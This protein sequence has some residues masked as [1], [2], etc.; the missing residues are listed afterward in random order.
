MI[1]LIQRVKQARVQ[2]AGHTVGE[3]GQGILV[4]LG[5]EKNDDEIKARK[6]SQKVMN[7]RIFSDQRGKMNLNVKQVEGELLIVSQFT[8]VADTQSGNR[9]SFSSAAPAEL[10][11]A[12]YQY[13]TECCQTNGIPCQTGVFGADMQVS[14]LNDGP[15]TFQLQV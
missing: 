15:V 12:L 6:L 11:E 3:I 4:L 10:G 1:A 13:F 7:Y 8:L 5:V 9:P 2:V 14:L